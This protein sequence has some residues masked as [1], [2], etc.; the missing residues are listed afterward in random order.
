MESRPRA[1]PHYL[2]G[3]PEA[4]AK[5]SLDR[6]AASEEKQE[7]RAKVSRALVQG[8]AVTRQADI[9]MEI[10]RGSMKERWGLDIS[11][12]TQENFSL[13][14]LDVQ[15]RRGAVGLQAFYVGPLG[16]H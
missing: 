15:C 6:V 12:R 13:E 11:C 8:R 4:I 10:K 1:Y 7:L 2:P 16:S 5:L 9:V 3:H 14:L